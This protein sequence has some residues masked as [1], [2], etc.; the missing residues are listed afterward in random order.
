M[1]SPVI[2]SRSV[3][4]LNIGG[5]IDEDALSNISNAANVSN[6]EL[7]R[8]KQ[9]TADN[10][11][12]DGYFA[13]SVNVIHNNA[14]TD[15]SEELSSSLSRAQGTSA[16]VDGSSLISK[17]SSKINAQ[18][19]ITY[20]NIAGG[21]ATGAAAA[22][23]ASVATANI[24]SKTNAFLGDNSSI[25]SDKNIDINA[26]SKVDSSKL[27]GIIGAASGFIGLSAV[28]AVA[29]E[30]SEP[31]LLDIDMEAVQQQGEDLR[32]AM[33]IMNQELLETN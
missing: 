30:P 28:V 16:F 26:V 3:S 17:G 21:L 29:D 32:L 1:P 23:G 11:G 6:T 33:A 5:A 19:N 9:L 24:D 15:V 14:N 20:D 4:V 12:N 31:S 7:G 8:N 22:V 27:L 2:N 25:V 13:D 10:L 18:D